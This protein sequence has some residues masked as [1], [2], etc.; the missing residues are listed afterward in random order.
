MAQL[1]LPSR[2]QQQSRRKTAEIQ[3]RRIQSIP[4]HSTLQHRRRKRKPM[5][6]QQCQQQTNPPETLPRT[7]PATLRSASI[8]HLRRRQ[9]NYHHSDNN[10]AKIRAKND[11]NNPNSNST[12][13]NSLQNHNRNLHN[14]PAPPILPHHPRHSVPNRLHDRLHPLHLHMRPCPVICQPS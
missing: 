6:Y 13:L 3:F 10:P 9:H 1:L 14:H 11:H 7:S 2:S 4:N 5:C 8:V 12:P